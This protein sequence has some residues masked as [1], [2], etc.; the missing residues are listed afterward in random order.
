MSKK[1]EK[2]KSSVPNKKRESAIYRKIET[3]TISLI[4]RTT[5]LPGV[6]M[7]QETCKRMTNELIECCAAVG[8]AYGTT[9]YDERYSYLEEMEVHLKLVK[10]CIKVLFEY[11]SVTNSR[12]MTPENIAEYLMILDDIETQRERWSNSTLKTLLEQKAISTENN[13]AAGDELTQAKG[14]GISRGDDFGIPE[15]T[16]FMALDPKRVVIK[17]SPF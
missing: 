14:S 15:N 5:N 4:K 7:I 13:G 16:Q 10:T 11:A 12:F 6:P 9:S 8:Y 2:P 3:L 1:D 17:D